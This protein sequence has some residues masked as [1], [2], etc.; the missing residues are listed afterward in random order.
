MSQKVKGASKRVVQGGKC[1]RQANSSLSGQKQISST[2]SLVLGSS[3]T[4]VSG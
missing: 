1:K 4:E 2:V 3:D